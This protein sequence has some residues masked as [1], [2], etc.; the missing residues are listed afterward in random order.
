MGV[1]AAVE[2]AE[3][4]LGPLVD[5]GNVPCRSNVRTAWE[6]ASNKLC[7]RLMERTPFSGFKYS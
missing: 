6:D 1:G 2:Q 5:V 7:N 3:T 4:L